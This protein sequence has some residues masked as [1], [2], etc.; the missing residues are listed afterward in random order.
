MTSVTATTAASDGR[1]GIRWADMGPFIA[2]AVVVLIG[3]LI[4]SNFITGTNIANVVTRSRGVAGHR[5][6]HRS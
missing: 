5:G 3:A 1:L 6:P 4:N 2:L